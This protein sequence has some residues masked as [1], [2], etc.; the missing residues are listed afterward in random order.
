ME[1][2]KKIQEIKN[3]IPENV[4]LVAVSKTKPVSDLQEAYN[5][6]QRVFGEN[7]IQEMVDKFD[8]LPKDIQ[9]HM[10]GHLQSN[11]VKYMAH[12]VNLIHGVDK[13]K[14]LKEIN[15][16]AKKHNRVINCL[17]QAKI[18]KE[19]T[20]FGLSF[21][22]IENILQSS[23][24]EALENIKIVGFM[25]MATFT[26]NEEQLQEEFLS[27]KDFFNSQQLKA[28][29]D[30]CKL[31]TLSMGMSADYNLAI[32]NGSTMIR[33]GSSIFGNRNYN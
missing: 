15:K 7:K 16:Q 13:F 4:T 3:S 20:K 30:N 21:E 33:V 10:I 23:E 5:G 2:Q 19:D 12:F 8:V 28:K 6:G 32:K 29:T 25:G 26:D 27:L 14:T 11:K 18:A 24:L 17:L 31:E 22:E 9:W 1:I